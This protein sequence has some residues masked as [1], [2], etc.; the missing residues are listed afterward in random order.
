MSVNVFEYT[1]I[2]FAL[3]PFKETIHGNYYIYSHFLVPGYVL[4]FTST[5][6]T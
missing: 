3:L 4:G 5:I 1:Y 2:I 6:A